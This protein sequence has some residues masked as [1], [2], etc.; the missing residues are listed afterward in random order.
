M[1]T[2]RNFLGSVLRAL[3]ASAVDRNQNLWA[4]G[5]LAW[6]G[7][8]GLQCGWVRALFTQDPVEAEKQIASLGRKATL[9]YKADPTEALEQIAAIGYKEL[10]LAP[11]IGL[12][13]EIPVL[14]AAGLS[15]PSAYFLVPKNIDEWKQ[16]IDVAKHH[17]LSYMTVGSNPKLDAEGW[18]RLIDLFN[19]CGTLSEA[20]GIQFCYHAHFREFAPI[21]K[22]TA[23]DMMLTQL[24]PNILKMEMDVF[25]VVYA[26]VDPVA[27]FQRYPGRFPLLHIKDFRAGV[28]ANLQ[29]GPSREGPSPF[30]PVGQGRIDWRRIFARASV[31]GAKHIFV[32]Q[33]R[34]DTP[35]IEAVKISLN[36]LKNLRL[37]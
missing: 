31:A 35:V 20:A 5:R 3:G 19:Q 33:D 32:E 27:Y 17:E 16:S 7:P 37:S 24:G 2:R 1:T 25:W 29:E 18:K 12:A 22:T 36:Y 13:P 34:S 28:A 10:E 21:D 30:V 8:I 15:A 9:D 11:N 4:A 14:R 6:P 26:G 23:Y